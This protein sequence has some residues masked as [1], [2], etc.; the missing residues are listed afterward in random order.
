MSLNLALLLRESAA[1]YPQKTALAIGDTNLT[2]EVV[3]LFA[4]RFAGG[5]AS[6][7]VEPGQH[8][9]LLLPNVPHFT[10]AYFGAHYAAA[11]VVP[12]NVLLTAD[13]IAYHLEDSEAVALVAW[14][15]F[16]K[17]AEEAFARVNGCR[18]LVVARANPT[19]WSAPEGSVNMAALVAGA[20]PVTDLPATGP[21][22][23][24]VILYTSGTTGKPKGAELTHFNLLFNALSASTRVVLLEADT[25]ALATLPLF[26]SFGQTVMQNAPIAA[27]GT[28]VLLPRFD[29]KAAFDLMQS[30]HVNF[31]GGVPTM[32]LA[33]L[34][35]PEAE[36]YDLSGLT[37]C[38][39]G[40]A[41]MP[42]E[43]MVAFDEKYHVNILEGY[44][45]SETSPIASFNPL[46]RP[47]KAGSIG[48]P[49]WGVDLRL[50]DDEGNV[51]E[52]PGTRGEIHIKGHNVMKGYWKRP[53]ATA[54]VMSN[55]WF[56]TGDIA[57]R[58]A[59]GYYFIVDRKKDLIIRG[60]FNVYP[61]EVEEILYTHPAVAEAA[62]I[63]TEHPT[64]GEEVKA[65][66]VLKSGMSATQQEIVDHCRE[67][68][69]AYKYPRVV[70]FREELPKTATGKILK[71]E[72]REL[73]A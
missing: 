64:H 72:L 54:E 21:D 7:G 9:A 29:P 71:R 11:P 39:S 30:H 51:I 42:V 40:G 26:H 37:W 55:G 41:S 36:R 19:D 62:V 53:E 25:V 23:A 24:A 67:H 15:G 61:R 65:V 46:D 56:A 68:L 52:G 69:A 58:D 60:G 27:G 50:V 57:T 32:Y 12:L 49:I 5:L 34:H 43:V 66:V 10:I 2:Y 70:E 18:H 45:L 6:L 44:G 8:V 35:Y 31:F 48:L 73:R 16:L 14:E 22:D 1:K 38:V 33:L 17:A 3:H 28:V 20:E 63:G 59:D 4:Q 47:K 13:E